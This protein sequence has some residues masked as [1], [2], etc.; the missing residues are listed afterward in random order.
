[1]LAAMFDDDPLTK[2]RRPEQRIPHTHDHQQFAADQVMPNALHIAWVDDC[3]LT[4]ECMSLALSQGPSPIVVTP[5]E[6]VTDFIAQPA[7]ARIDLIVLHAHTLSDQLP[8]DIT[9]LR[10]AGF[11][12]PIVLVTQDGDAE[13]VMAVKQALRL[14]A[15]GHLSTRSS[16]IEMAI[17]SFAFA[18]EGGTFASMELLLTDEGLAEKPRSSRASGG[19]S[20]GP[21]ARQA[22][23]EAAASVSGS[24]NDPEAPGDRPRRGRDPHKARKSAQPDES[25]SVTGGTHHE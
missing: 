24:S 21:S 3:Q 1:M 6:Y 15:S 18:H 20:R 5:F 19:R 23:T 22:R 11:Q 7:D 25:P 2:S 16:S 13:Q 8:H 4:R 9:A 17:S 10:R 14:G 12:Q